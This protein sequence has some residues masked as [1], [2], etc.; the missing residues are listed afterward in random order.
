MNFSLHVLFYYLGSAVT[1][2]GTAHNLP[3]PHHSCPFFNGC[4]WPGP[5]GD[6]RVYPIPP[7]AL[8]C[9]ENCCLCRCYCPFSGSSTLRIEFAE[10]TNTDTAAH[11]CKWGLEPHSRDF[12]DRMDA[13]PA[14]ELKHHGESCMSDTGKLTQWNALRETV[15]ELVVSEENMSYLREVDQDIHRK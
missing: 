4:N 11:W 6:P 9:F 5:G 3:L 8:T 2:C 10:S 1:S 12:S 14:G 15:S 13:F 7:V